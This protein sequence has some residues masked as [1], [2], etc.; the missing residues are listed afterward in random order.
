MYDYTDNEKILVT[1]KT[2]DYGNSSFTKN[3]V[4]WEKESLNY[5]YNLID[6][7]KKVNI[8]D[9]GANVGLYSL[10]AKHLPNSQFYSFEPFT[11]LKIKNET[12]P[13]LF[14]LYNYNEA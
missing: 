2:V 12:K 4:I 3:S 1:S 13:Y 7:N 14:L 10:Y 5:F 9:I 8:V 11:P 6:K